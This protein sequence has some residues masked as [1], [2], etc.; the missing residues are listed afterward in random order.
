MD[1]KLFQSLEWRCIGPHRGGRVVA[2]AGDPTEP[3]TFYFGGCAGGVWK[4]TSGGALWENVSDGYL[5]APPRSARLPSPH[6]RR[7]CIYAGTGEATIRGNVSHGDGVYKSTDGGHTWR[8]VGLADTRHIGA[9]VVH[10]TNPDIVYVAALGHAW[11][12]NAERGVFRSRDGGAT[13]QKVL[14]KSENAGAVDLA[15]DPNHPDILY[16]TIWQA[17][18]YPHALVSGGEESGLWRST[19]GGDTWKEISRAKGLPQSGIYGKIGVAVSPAQPGR[20]W[21]IVEARGQGRQRRGG[22]YRSEDGGET[23]ERVNDRDG[24]AQ[25]SLVLHAHLRRPARSRHRL[26]AQPARAGSPSTAAR[27]SSGCPHR[28]A[29]TTTSGSTRATRTA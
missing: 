17:R 6:P 4:T 15:M 13:W 8:N 21:A 24:P 12:P 27:P 18:R 22:L 25:A 14:F 5:H 10:P 2:V 29:T 20:V 7:T 26:G 3:G 11:G 19:D 28:T 1:D 23:W 16:A 9:I